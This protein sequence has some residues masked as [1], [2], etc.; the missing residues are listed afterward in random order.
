MVIPSMVGVTTPHRW[1]PMSVAVPTM[2]VSPAMHAWVAL[3]DMVAADASIIPY[4]MSTVTV[5]TAAKARI[6]L[7]M[8]QLIILRC[9]QRPHVLIRIFLRKIHW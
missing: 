8:R 1:V 7:L 4:T 6:A 2:A 5:T 9:K 3:G